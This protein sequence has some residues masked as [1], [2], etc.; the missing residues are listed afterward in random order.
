MNSI[1]SEYFTLATSIKNKENLK[2]CLFRPLTFLRTSNA[3]LI[4]NISWQSVIKYIC[5]NFSSKVKSP[6]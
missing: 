4:E 3:F 1:L 6:V 2:Y 5:S